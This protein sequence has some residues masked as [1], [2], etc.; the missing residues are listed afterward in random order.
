MILC[1]FAFKAAFFRSQLIYP[2]CRLP[3][4]LADRFRDQLWIASDTLDLLDDESFNF[5]RWNRR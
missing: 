2:L 3:V 1:K 4:S 5:A